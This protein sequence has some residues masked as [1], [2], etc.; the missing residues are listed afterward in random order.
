MNNNE[1]DS[2]TFAEKWRG[3]WMLT[4]LG[5]IYLVGELGHYLIGVI[6]RDVAEDLHF[7]DLG[8]FERP[9]VPGIHFGIC[10]N[11]NTSDICTNI[12]NE[13]GTFA[14]EWQYTGLGLDYQLLAG[15]SFMAV[16]TVAG[17][18]WGIAGDKTNRVYLLFAATLLFSI[19]TACTGLC[20]K[21]WHVIV[22]RVVQGVGVAACSPLA[23][24]MICDV[25]GQKRR[26]TAMSLYNCGMYIGYGLSYAVGTY[27][28]QANLFNEGWRATFVI[29]GIPG[30]VLAFLLLITVRDPEPKPTESPVEEKGA[31]EASYTYEA[32]HSYSAHPDGG[33]DDTE[34]LISNHQEQTASQA[35]RMESDWRQCFRFVTLYLILAACLRR[36]AGYTLRYN[37]ALYFQVYY[38]GLDVG[39]WLTAIYCIGGVLGS[40][41]GGVTSDMLVNK[42]GVKARAVVLAV[43]QLVATPFSVLMFYM[44][45]PYVFIPQTVGYLFGAMWFGAM[46]TILVEIIPSSIRS[47]AFGVAFFIMENFGGNFPVIVHHLSDILGYRLALVIMYPGE[48]ILSKIAY[49]QALSNNQHKQ[50]DESAS[51]D[52]VLCCLFLQVLSSS[53]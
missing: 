31:K 7:G 53:F 8:C 28:T 26:G 5:G 51:N 22:C 4:V 48:L 17:I 11:A 39:W 52:N 20:Q 50:Q 25:F 21:F 37:S 33:T 10:E 14:C 46:F 49:V 1:P 42:L 29:S 34:S 23:A 19:S 45:P 3:S 27:V 18:F 38:P 32:V 2:V 41:L 13:H 30:I 6:S 40:V 12:T 44:D 16:F 47:T 9:D 24:G 35:G 36:S 43:G 15:P